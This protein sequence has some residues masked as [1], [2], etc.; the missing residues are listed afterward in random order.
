MTKLA[1]RRKKTP[2]GTWC[3]LR[4]AVIV[5]AAVLAT[6]PGVA[7]LA[8]DASGTGAGPPKLT[9]SPLP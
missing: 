7:A 8:S 3:R 1:N 4:A 2:G 5:G 6:G 9:H